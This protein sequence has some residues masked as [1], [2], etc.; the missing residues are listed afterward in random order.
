MLE[1][2]ITDRAQANDEHRPCYLEASNVHQRVSSGVQEMYDT[3]QD[4]GSPVDLRYL[5]AR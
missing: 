3:Q 1:M 4:R 2:A 5:A